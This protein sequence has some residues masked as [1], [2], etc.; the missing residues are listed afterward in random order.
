MKTT[1]N[2][3]ALAALALA[4]LGGCAS[5]PPGPPPEVVRL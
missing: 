3:I 2:R 1:N 5:V 4:L